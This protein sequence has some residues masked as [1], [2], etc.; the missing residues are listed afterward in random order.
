MRI[1]LDTNILVSAFIAE[2]GHPAAIIDLA[3]TFSEIDTVLSVPIL[4]EF[5]DVLSRQEVR[6]R[7]DYSDGE[8]AE[9]VDAVRKASVIVKPTSDFKVIVEDP[10][11]D[12]VINTAFDG[13]AEYIVSGDRHLLKV[14]RFRDIKIVSPRSMLD[15]FNKKFGEV[16]RDEL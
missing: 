12:I 16:I 7:F 4:D 3:L 5:K 1:T 10:N 9:F 6:E 11:D 13:K 14:G 2:K 8:I 15:I